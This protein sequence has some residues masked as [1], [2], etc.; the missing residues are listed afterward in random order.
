MTSD[1][2]GGGGGGGGLKNLSS[3]DV[4]FFSKFTKNKTI[5]FPLPTN[6]WFREVIANL[7][8]QLI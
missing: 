6:T 7:I 8:D 4:K 2:E 3:T 1:S 5:A